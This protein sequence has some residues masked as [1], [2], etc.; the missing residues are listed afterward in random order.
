[1][2]VKNMDVPICD[3]IETL[4]ENLSAGSLYVPKEDRGDGCGYCALGWLLHQRGCPDRSLWKSRTETHLARLSKTYV[5]EL[6]GRE[7]SLINANDSARPEY[8]R[9]AARGTARLITGCES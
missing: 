4:P 2:S 1:M 3:L 7:W 6:H 8:R 9:E 5:P